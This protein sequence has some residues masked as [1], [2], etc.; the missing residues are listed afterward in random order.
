MRI[1]PAFPRRVLLVLLVG[2]ALGLYPLIR[3]GSGDVLLAVS[4]GAALS[5]LNVMAGFLT[6]EY[7]FGKSWTTFLKAAVGGMGVRMLVMLG[8]MVLMLKVVGLDPAAFLISLLGFYAVFL[9]LEVLYLQSKVS[10]KN[11]R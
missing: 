4:V 8:V 2:A 3:I 7:S 9:V 6:I 1:D 11:Q 5:T 10:A